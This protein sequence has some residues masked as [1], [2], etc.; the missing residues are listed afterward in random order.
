MIIETIVLFALAISGIILHRVQKY[1]MPRS[2]FYYSRL[3]DGIDEGISILGLVIRFLIPI[4]IGG[5]AGLIAFKHEFS[6]SPE[7]YGAMASFLV[8]FLL[9]WPD[10][11]HPEDIS[12]QFRSSSWKL[13]SLYALL[14]SFFPIQGFY[15]AKL[16]IAFSPLLESVNSII[17]W[18]SVLNNL[19]SNLIFLI[20]ESIFVFYFI[21]WF[22]Q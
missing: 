5:A 12:P 10:I 18:T 22:K 21:R 6:I 20:L 19:L 7:Y 11:L 8:I 3:I 4:I 16:F 13:F 1:I 15:G 14:F 9:V 17:D 2:Y